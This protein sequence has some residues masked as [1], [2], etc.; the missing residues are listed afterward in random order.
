MAPKI[1]TRFAPS[2]T[3]YLHIG[4]LRTALFNYLYAKRHNGEF[5]LR[6][7]DTDMARNSKD[8]AEA[9][10]ESFEWVGL[11]HDRE[12][13]YQSK[14]L[15]L[16]A[17][18]IQKLLDE[19]KAYH[20]YMSKEELESKR[21]EAQKQGK[22]WKYDNRYRDFS[23]TPPEGI[24]P[25]VRIKAPL[26]G[27]I[28]FK[29]GVKGTIR[30]DAKEIDD[31]V[32][33]RADGS[34]TYNFV[35]AVDDALMGV[36]DV[37]RGDDHLSNTPKQIIIYQALGF[38]IPK[39]FHVPM[40]LSPEGKKLSKRDG[41]MG[42]MEYQKMGYL[43][44]A[45]LNFLVRLGWSYGD[46]EIFSLRQLLEIFD[47]YALNSAPSSYNQEKLLWLNHHYIKQTPN[48]E[49]LELVREFGVQGLEEYE[50][51]NASAEALDALFYELKD[52]SKTLVEFATHYNEILHAPT[53]YDPK[54]LK[55]LDSQGA[56]ILGKLCAILPTLPTTSPNDIESALSAFSEA[57]GLKMGQ[58]M[59][60]LRLGILGK[61][62]G[63]AMGVAI[64]VLG[65]RECERRVRTLLDSQEG[66]CE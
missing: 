11:A 35:V 16:Y 47:P 23:G 29:D 24:K 13:F 20:C 3:G 18:Y 30:V 64:F 25:V 49:L 55:R 28:E 8:A 36:S 33:A 4:G 2:P 65:A 63:I 62:G 32:I 26:E 58:V 43:P 50:G 5:L 61:G 52:R 6:I 56:E 38:A 39:F 51:I 37:I 34:P 59:P 54:L 57:N 27:V 15:P 42:V 46:E 12:V 17:Q 9:I 14:R 60:L 66:K 1:I 21:E 53:T 10:I 48:R 7:E 22:V 19:G 31:F 40:I 41:A 45:L 44:Q